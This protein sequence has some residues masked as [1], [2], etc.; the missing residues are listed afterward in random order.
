MKTRPPQQ[1]RT[2][3][4]GAKP[5]GSRAALLLAPV[6]VFLLVTGVGVFAAAPGEPEPTFTEKAQQAAAGRARDL[7][8]DAE[9]LAAGAGPAAGGYAQAAQLLATQA[10]GLALPSAGGSDSNGDGGG[11]GDGGNEAAD[12]SG[13]DSAPEPITSAAFLEALNASARTSLEDAGRAEPGIARLLASAGSSQR[14]QAASLGGLL[15]LPVDAPPGA[16]LEAP[17]G[18]ECADEARGSEDHR[19]RL[20]AAVHTE[21]QAAYAYEVAAARGADPA[22]LLAGAREHAAVAGTAAAVLAGLCAPA[23]ARAAAFALDP[24]FLT[25]P[26]AGIARLEQELSVFYGSMVGSGGT[27][28]RRWAVDR[29]NASV[30]RSFAADGIAEPFPGIPVEQQALPPGQDSGPKTDDPEDTEN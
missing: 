30:Q 12:A 21:E 6:L 13:S 28:L 29:L 24:G 16:V 14:Q 17:P 1:Q 8:A 27:E 10:T 5:A 23:P 22:G 7:A 2:G 26:R 19:S 15:G 11:K 3:K 9:V 18:E 25:D 20:L 4:N